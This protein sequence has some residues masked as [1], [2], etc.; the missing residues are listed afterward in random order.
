VEDTKGREEESEDEKKIREKE[1][2]KWNSQNYAIVK[3]SK[4]PLSIHSHIIFD[5]TLGQINY[6]NRGRR[7]QQGPQPFLPCLLLQ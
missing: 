3:S 7:R 6:P 2:E 5:L 1:D 4:S